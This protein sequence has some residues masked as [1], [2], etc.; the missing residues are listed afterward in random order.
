MVDASVD[1]PLRAAGY[2][3]RRNVRSK[4][5]AGVRHVVDL[6]QE[7]AKD[8]H[9]RISFT[10][11]CGISVLGANAYLWAGWDE[12]TDASSA[13]IVTRIGSAFDPPG[14]WWVHITADATLI[15]PLFG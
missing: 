9:P 4:E 2:T 8:P 14:D 15:G 6:Q 5:I 7:R 13:Q 3:R 1:P 12:D 10:L 11:N